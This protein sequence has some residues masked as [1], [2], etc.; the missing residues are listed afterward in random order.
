M[1]KKLVILLAMALVLGLALSPAAFAKGKPTPLPGPQ[2]V[3]S[4]DGDV[5]L[6]VETPATIIAP[7]GKISFGLWGETFKFYFKAANLTVGDEYTLRVGDLLLPLG[8]FIVVASD[9]TGSLAGEVASESFT[10]QNV[11]LTR[12]SDFQTLTS[13]YPISFKYISPTP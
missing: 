2:V 12:T 7:W 8:N 1:T 3:K 4:F 6:F 5:Y 13:F 11:T 9:G 10:N